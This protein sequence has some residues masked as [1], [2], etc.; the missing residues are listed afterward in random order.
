MAA[1]QEPYGLW[2][3]QTYLIPALAWWIACCADVVGICNDSASGPLAQL[4]RAGEVVTAICAKIRGGITAFRAVIMAEGAFFV[5]DAG[6]VGC[7]R[8]IGADGSGV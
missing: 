8:I 1:T 6:R 7:A 5:S 3:K 4:A 2:D